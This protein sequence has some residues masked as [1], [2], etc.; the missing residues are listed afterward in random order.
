MGLMLPIN[1]FIQERAVTAAKA[2]PARIAPLL[3]VYRKSHGF[4]PMKLDEL[5]SKPSVPR[6]LRSSYG[7]RSNGH[8]YT[9]C[10]PQPG[11]IIDVWDYDSETKSWH[12]ST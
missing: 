12:L 2:Y 3:E 8:H 10:F 9:F 4:Y 7:Y 6:L 11:G 1:G 5:P